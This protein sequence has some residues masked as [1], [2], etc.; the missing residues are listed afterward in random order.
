MLPRPLS[1]PGG[2]MRATLVVLLLLASAT[3]PV[4]APAGD[5]PVCEALYLRT[6]E[7][8]AAA[9]TRH[10]RSLMLLATIIAAAALRVAPPVIC[11]VPDASLSDRRLARR[12]YAVNRPYEREKR[13]RRRN[14]HT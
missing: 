8:A 11:A 7:A 4:S 10:R 12:L 9:V 2:S 6:P 5:T 1:V 3:V 14:R 13:G